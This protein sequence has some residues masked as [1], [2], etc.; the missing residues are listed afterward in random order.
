MSAQVQSYM[1]IDGFTVLDPGYE[2]IETNIY[3]NLLNA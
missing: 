3:E 2:R 1:Y